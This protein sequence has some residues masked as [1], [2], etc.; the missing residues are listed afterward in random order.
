MLLSNAIRDLTNHFREGAKMV[1]DAEIQREI[2]RC[3]ARRAKSS[4]RLEQLV[5][6]RDQLVRQMGSG[7]SRQ[8]SPSNIC[9][10]S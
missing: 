1:L 10:V 6:R 8:N 9:D 5:N 3:F 4:E 7:S 2:Q